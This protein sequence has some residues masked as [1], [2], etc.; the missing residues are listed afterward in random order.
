VQI[1]R[2]QIDH[3]PAL[4][5]IDQQGR[6]RKLYLTQMAYASIGQAGQVLAEEVASLLPGH[7][8]LTSYRSLAQIP[9]LGPA[10]QATLPSATGKAAVPLGP[11]Q[12]H[13]VMFFATWLAE[14]S[15]LR[16][17][18]LALG[19]YAA[20]ARSAHLPGLVAVDE[21]AAEPSVP[22]VAA[23]L[24][25][26]GKPLGYPVALDAAGRLAD[27]YG[28]QDQPW[29]ALVNASGTIIWHHDGWLPLP[30]LEAAA[31]KA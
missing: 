28:V 2:G 1:D 26:L 24:R 13:L 25:G 8:A 19:S 21:Q 7:P 18:L 31:R 16:G 4:Y 3:T 9:A 15:G 27:G 20:R 10:A 29:F 22:T 11:G 17:H 30:A 5:V 23:Y 14:T 12:P 6:E